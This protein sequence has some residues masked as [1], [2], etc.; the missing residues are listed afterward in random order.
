MKEKKMNINDLE[1]YLCDGTK[2]EDML[3]SDFDLFR[4]DELKQS[5]GRNDDMRLNRDFASYKRMKEDEF[6]Q[7]CKRREGY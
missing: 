3:E 2:V 6:R 4:V 7:E 1:N 5:Y